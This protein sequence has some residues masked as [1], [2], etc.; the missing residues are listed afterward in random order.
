MCDAIMSTLSVASRT[1]PQ[2]DASAHAH[3]FGQEGIRPAERRV[4]MVAMLT[5][6]VMGLEVAAGWWTGSM[7]LLADG[8]HMG[9]H[10]VALGLAAG[11]YAMSRRYARDRR[12]SLGSGKINDLAAYTSALI[13]AASTAWTA[14]ESAQRLLSP[15]PLRPTEALVVAVLGL[16]VNLLSAW[17]LGGAHDHGHEHDHHHDH[18]IH[19]HDHNLGAALA[20]VLSDAATSVAAIA[21]LLAAGAWGWTWLDPLI[22]LLALGV[23]ARWAVGLLRQTGAVLL[24]AEGPDEQRRQVRTRL[25]AVADSRVTDLHLWSVG[26]GAWTLAASVVSHGPAAPDAYKAVLAGLPGIHHPLVEIHACRHCPSPHGAES[27]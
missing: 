18:P 8:V 3:D 21:G 16:A 24:D 27:P 20:H 11:A 10:A 23:V 22:A 26:Q 5:V 14:I 13:L 12:L 25:E 7:A 4:G 1:C 15:E 9:G 19:V 2:A 17:L 6:A